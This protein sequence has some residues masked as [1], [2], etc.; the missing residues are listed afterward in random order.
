[1]PTGYTAAIRDGI[2]FD[3][4]AMSCARAFGALVM[5]RDEPN[6]AA[7]PDVIKP[8]TYHRDAAIRAEARLAELRA[9]TEAEATASALRARDEQ[10]A[11]AE[12]GMADMAADREKYEAMRRQVQAWAPPSGAHIGLK[13]FMLEQI[14]SSIKFDCTGEWYQKQLAEARAAVVDGAAWRAEQITVTERS[15]ESHR[16][17]YAKDVA[18]AADRTNWVRQLRESLASL[19][20]A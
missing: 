5:M 4:F 2:T 19:T 10:I 14:D 17:D 8:S 15:L 3:Q 6:D 7:I 13:T 9:M 12:R 11:S 1:M 16:V 18:I 20:T